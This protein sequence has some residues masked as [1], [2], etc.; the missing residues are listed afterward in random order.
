MF[1]LQQTQWLRSTAFHPHTDG[2]TEIVNKVVKP[3]YVALL[4]SRPRNRQSGCIGLILV[5]ILLNTCRQK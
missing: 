1:R 3:T 4:M 2:Q 5:T